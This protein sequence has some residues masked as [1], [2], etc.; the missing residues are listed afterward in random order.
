MA[1]TMIQWAL[2]HQCKLV[3]S[4]AGAPT[5]R[6]REQT[7][8]GDE[9]ELFAVA[10]TESG[11]SI[12]RKHGFSPLNSGMISGI[13]AILLNEACLINFEVIVFIIKFSRR[14]LISV[15]QQWCIMRSQK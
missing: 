15:L 10:S 1:T 6:E 14:C 3:I 11:L 13:P 5:N 9:T 4:A 12:I 8:A 7:P 2:D